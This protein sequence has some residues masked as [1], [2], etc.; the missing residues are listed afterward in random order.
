MAITET[1]E[2]GDR[3]MI[4]DGASGDVNINYVYVDGIPLDA[5]QSVQKAE[6]HLSKTVAAYKGG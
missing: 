6:F 3:K 4:A 2:K 1:S 5:F